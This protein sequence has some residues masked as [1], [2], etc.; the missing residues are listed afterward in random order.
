MDAIILSLVALIPAVLLCWYIYCKDRIEKEP[1][2]LLLLLF[3][4]G[5]TVYLPVIWV[6]NHLIGLVDQALA[7][8]IT[9]S[10][11]GAANFESKGSFV[12]HSAACGFLAVALVEETVKWSLL[13]L[14]TRKNKNFN[15]LFDGI[16]YAV[17]L[18]LGF[19]AMENVYYAVRDGWTT[20]VLRSLNS[21]P[22][23]MMFGV[24]MGYC[25]TMWHTYLVARKKEQELAS[26]EKIACDKPFHSGIWLAASLLFPILLHGIYS[27][28][29]FLTSDEM[30]VVFYLFIICLYGGGFWGIRRLADKDSSDDRV[31]DRM[32]RK[33]Y[34]CASCPGKNTPE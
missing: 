24:L 9:Y 2:S 27:F 15:H 3:G 8:R 30:L 26:S 34:P 25:Y 7:S 13:Y 19:A 16:V 20:F 17:F 33:K 21:V 32:I 10:L 5:V 6:E 31:A 12:L 1:V 11:T 14:I 22:G 28:L 18:A 4:S 23:H 29:R